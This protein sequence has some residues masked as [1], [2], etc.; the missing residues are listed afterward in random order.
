MFLEGQDTGTKEARNLSRQYQRY[1]LVSPDA[2]EGE[3][4][5]GEGEGEDS[6][7]KGII[8]E[9][10]APVDLAD[11]QAGRYGGAT[12][13]LYKDSALFEEVD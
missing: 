11:S 10:K 9:E 1:T 7:V 6:G 2:V 3:L 5:N 13:E 8:E 12:E 4:G